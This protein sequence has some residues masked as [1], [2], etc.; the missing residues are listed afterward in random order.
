MAGAVFTGCKEDDPVV[1]PTPETPQIEVVGAESGYAF[2][3][4]DGEDK[5]KTFTVYATAP[6]TVKKDA[7]WFVVEPSSGKAGEEIRVTLTAV[8][9]DGAAREG[10]VTVVANAGTYKHP[11]TAE[12]SF[13]VSQTA[14][15]SAE[16]VVNGI[17]DGLIAFP[18]RDNVPYEFTV[19]NAYDWTL[20]AEN[21]TWYAVAPKSGKGGESVKVV[22]TPK[23]NDKGEINEG[24]RKSVV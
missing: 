23:D 5:A 11:V 19:E 18:A 15:R 9:N 16:F 4:Y 22:V 2:A 10:K 14:Y 7:G 21:E 13:S 24:D 20:A 1:P 17:E 6:W 12:Y 8:E 3:Y